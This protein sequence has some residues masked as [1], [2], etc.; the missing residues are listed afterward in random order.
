MPEPIVILVVDDLPLQRQALVLMLKREGQLVKTASC[1]HGA[2]KVIEDEVVDAVLMDIDLGHGRNGV[3]AMEELRKLPHLDSVPII[4]MT[5]YDETSF[6]V[7][8]F[9][10]FF[11][12]T[13]SAREVKKYH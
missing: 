7:E 3:D 8:E 1:L 2:L 12:Q 9:D 5:G 13:H 4:A 11:T 10:G 6:E